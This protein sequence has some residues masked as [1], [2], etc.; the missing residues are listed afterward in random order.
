MKQL[1][2]LSLAI[3]ICSITNAQELSGKVRNI[4]VFRYNPSDTSKLYFNLLDLYA[5]NLNK[6]KLL[7]ENELGRVYQLPPDNMRCLAPNFN[8]NMGVKS[9]NGAFVVPMPNPLKPKEMIPK[10]PKTPFHL[11][12]DK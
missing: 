3:L 2:L 11:N 7:F 4:K 9:S 10:F 1:F 8:S 6:G 12:Q 5:D